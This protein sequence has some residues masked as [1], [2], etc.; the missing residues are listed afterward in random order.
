MSTFFSVVGAIG[1]AIALVTVSLLTFLVTG[2][3]FGIGVG[4]A[5]VRDALSTSS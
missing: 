4:V 3:I 5:K 1:I 2:A